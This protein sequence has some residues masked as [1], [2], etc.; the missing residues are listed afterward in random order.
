MS[1]NVAHKN[2]KAIQHFGNELD[3]LASV[4]ESLIKLNPSLV[5]A[6]L[7]AQIDDLANHIDTLLN[8]I[9]QLQHQSISI[10]LLDMDLLNKLYAHLKLAS[11]KNNWKL[12]IQNPQDIFQL[13][14]SYVH[15]NLDVVILVHVPC[16]TDSHL[17]TIYR[18]A[19]LPLPVSSLLQDPLTDNTACPPVIY[20]H[21][22][23]KQRPYPI[24]FTSNSSPCP[25]SPAPSSG[26]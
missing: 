5:Y 24:F 14:V 25:T 3:N 6:R 17:L 2:T 1:I 15:K 22:H 26:N 19:Y 4:V 11:N 20:P 21:P 12:L 13:N 18:Y 9:Q 8:T 7:Q 23:H 10:Q 16:L